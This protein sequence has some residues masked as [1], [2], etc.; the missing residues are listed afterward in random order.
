MYSYE[1]DKSTR[2]YKLTTSTGKYVAHEI[3]PVFAEE[4]QLLGFQ[5]HF[6]FDETERRPL[7]WCRNNTYIYNGEEV[8]LLHNTR[9]GYPL[10]AEYLV[11]KL[12]LQPVDID[13][14]V[15][16]NK[17][18][19]ELL[20]ANTLKRIK[21]MYEKH[22]DRQDVVY[23]GFSG[24]KDSVLLLDLCDR[25]L[26]QN[27]PVVF[28]DTTME[29]PDSYVLWEDIQKRYPER[30]FLKFTAD[31]SA[32]EN[33]RLFGPPSRSADWCCAIHK[34]SPAILG[35]KQ[36]LGLTALKALA[37]LGI[38]ADEGEG[39]NAYDGDVAIG[40]K[41][42]SQINAM[43][44]ID[45]GAH[46]LFLYHF[47]HSLCFHR[48]YRFG[49]PRVGC[50]MCP[51]S[52]DKYAFWVDNVYQDELK[53]YKQTI[54]NTTTRTFNDDNEERDFLSSS[55]W[56]ARRNGLELKMRLPAL[57]EKSIGIKSIWSHLNCDK[58]LFMEWLKTLGSIEQ[59]ENNRY[60]I[61]RLEG[62]SRS[63]SWKIDIEEQ[64]GRIHEVQC[65]YDVNGL[66]ERKR[67]QTHLSR[68]LC[69]ATACAGCRACEA[70]CSFGALHITENNVRI[71]ADKCAHC[72]K[73]HDIDYGCWRYKSIMTPNTTNSPLKS[74]ANYQNF[75]LR[76]SWLE[77]YNSEREEFRNTLS[78]G[79][80]MI[81]S[82]RIWFKQSYLTTDS[83]SLTPGKLLDLVTVNGTDDDL[84]WSLIWIALCNNSPLIKWFVTNV[85]FD[86]RTT[87]EELTD[88]LGD[89]VSASA[90]RG[91]LQALFNCFKESPIGTGD[92]PMVN[93][94]TKGAKSVAVTRV[95]RGISP[96]A[97]LYSLYVMG[98]VSERNGFTIS[99]MM[100]A[101][102]DS[103][104]ISPLT[105]FGMDVDEFKG[106]CMGI[107]SR[108]PKFLSCSFTLGLDE[109]RIFPD[110]K[111]LDDVI[112]LMLGE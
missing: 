1:W 99:D 94:E 44:I 46:E 12:K 11:D 81:D 95:R 63:C 79:G 75:G 47:E 19:I 103:P 104:F 33:W 61:S 31:K 49:L 70:E 2:G 54:L 96:M 5:S 105:A 58:K 16:K 7:L 102:F 106:Q 25:V 37:Y 52:S 71:E 43:P 13:K 83:K 108:Y 69:K 28:S 41:N 27:C 84:V 35:L 39:R 82:A 74:I 88:K 32:L 101:D 67:M 78:I 60:R 40:V 64:N 93:L 34:S 4:L 73:C 76:Q 89:I 87:Q 14:M 50:L 91:G 72:W 10:D 85:P 38:R 90:R 3:R 112:G 26:P 30:K 111:R 68:V 92:K 100:Q 97:V 55:Y 36:F 77:L 24:G 86:V 110:E 17:A 42:A 56:Q 22:K 18:I 65:H 80:P 53:K 59:L 51:K 15:K 9:M 8:A 109:V 6:A 107:A 45:W 62:V 23:V 66:Q 57:E 21:E 98:Q 29:L 20:V 48:A